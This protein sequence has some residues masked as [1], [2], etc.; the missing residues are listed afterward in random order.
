MGNPLAWSKQ[1]R[2]IQNKLPKVETVFANIKN[3]IQEW[4]A[5][6][7]GTLPKPD[8]VMNDNFEE[9]LFAETRERQLG[10]ILSQEIIDNE[11][12]WINYETE[13]TQVKLDIA[14]M[15]LDQLVK[16]TSIML[17]KIETDRI[18]K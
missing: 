11:E 1:T 9:E 15:L 6:E 7:A 13:E 17:N 2:I 10:I 8:F 5:I 14:D 16:E 18:H 4:C 12:T 3:I